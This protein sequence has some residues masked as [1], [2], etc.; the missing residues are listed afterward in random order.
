MGTSTDSTSVPHK[1][2][3]VA[4]VWLNPDQRKQAERQ[5]A[6]SDP[7]LKWLWTWL[8]RSVVS[9][10]L[11]IVIF[12]AIDVGASFYDC[13]NSETTAKADA[14]RSVKFHC[15]EMNKLGAQML[16]ECLKQKAV[17][18][19]NWFTHV[20]NGVVRHQMSRIWM[21]DYCMKHEDMCGLMA[22]RLLEIVALL[23]H[24]A[25]YFLSAVLVWQLWPVLMGLICRRVTTVAAPQ[26][27][28][29]PLQ[30]VAATN[31]KLD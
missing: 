2:L 13:Y 22:V 15:H 6:E 7:V 1:S 24:W 4:D 21:Y 27:T 16:N 17:L 8:K 26:A 20:W 3:Y 11:I 28:T 23:F 18:E 14:E 12:N 5:L 30:Q 10:I 19:R 31:A 9:F 25:P 29:T